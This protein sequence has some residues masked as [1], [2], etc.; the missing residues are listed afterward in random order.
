[1]KGVDR[2]GS[3]F[4]R[5]SAIG[6]ICVRRRTPRIQS[7]VNAGGARSGKKLDR[8]GLTGEGKPFLLTGRDD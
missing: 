3:D 5:G 7:G 1:M 8:S 2:L 4:L 6:S